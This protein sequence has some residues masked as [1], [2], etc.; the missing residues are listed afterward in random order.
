[1]IDQPT[2]LFSAPT[3]PGHLIPIIEQLLKATDALTGRILDSFY[4]ARRL[5][6]LLDTVRSEA[7]TCVRGRGVLDQC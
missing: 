6:A 1:M 7:V 3:G 5:R 4:D 2:D